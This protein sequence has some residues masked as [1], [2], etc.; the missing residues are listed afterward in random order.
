MA[1]QKKS[2]SGDALLSNFQH[3]TSRRVNIP[4]ATETTSG[5]FKGKKQTYRYNPHLS[6]KLRFDESGAW[7]QVRTIIE[8][9]IAGVKLTLSEIE[10]LR[11]IIGMGH[12]PWL[13]WAAKQEQQS[14]G[15]FAVDDVVL[16]IHE[17]ISTQAILTTARRE[18]ELDQDL[19]ARPRLHRDQ[20][21]QYYRHSMDWTNRIILGDSLQVMSSL[22]RREGL[23]GQV[24][25]IFMDPPYGI[26]FSSNWQ[27]ELGKR[28]VKDKDEDMTREPEMIRAYR[29]TW[30]LGVHSYLT[31]LK[32]RLL[33]AR[34]LLT[35]SGSAFVQISDENL[36]RVRLLM[37]EVFGAD[38]FCS[39]ISFQK[40]GSMA[41]N[42]LPTTVDF[43]IWYAKDRKS[44]RYSQLYAPRKSG[45]PSLDRYDQLRESS[46][47]SGPFRDG[48]DG[49]RFQLTSLFSDGASSSPQQF[50]FRGTIF[51]PKGNAHWKTSVDGL[52]RLAKAERIEPQGDR[53]RYVRFA[54][55]FNL[56]PISD[57][58]DS[59]QI[60]KE[61]LYVVQTATTVIQRCM[62]MTTSPGDIVLDPTCGSGTTAYVS[63]QWGRRWVT[64]DSSRVAI[65]I[66]RQRIL[67][68][69]YES[70]KTRDPSSGI[71]PTAPQNPGYGFFYRSVPHITLKSIAQNKSLDPIFEKN[72]PLIREHLRQLNAALKNALGSKHLLATLVGKLRAKEIGRAHV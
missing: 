11:S 49:A 32:Q 70:Y 6:P 16:H 65:A 15:E 43:I 67:T 54:D 30:E 55:D 37:D 14:K 19:F 35:T 24:Q 69:C 22:S 3:G 39:I 4:E 68:S 59:V 29:D 71:D 28:D 18:E 34:E 21:L 41:A 5:L 42:L 56:I 66:A 20:A 72:D 2:D 46:G 58:W 61:A 10:I 8:K 36:H 60:G 50:E 17:R 26:K 25:M 62:L 47:A 31:Y 7:D 44:A 12:Q 53:L 38:N 9:A 1:R 52:Q 51:E 45:D 33:I 27:N 48:E 13:E 57:R 23:A 63:E 40:T 64:I